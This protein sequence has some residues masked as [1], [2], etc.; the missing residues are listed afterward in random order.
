MLKSSKPKN[1][2]AS[3]KITGS[4]KKKC[5]TP[6]VAKKISQLMEL[7]TQ[8]LKDSSNIY[9]VTCIQSANVGIPVGHSADR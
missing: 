9:A 2:R 1:R 4:Y 8:A 7:R 6:I 3:K 5:V